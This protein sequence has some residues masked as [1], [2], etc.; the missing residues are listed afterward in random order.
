VSSGDTVG[1][2]Q[3]VALAHSEPPQKNTALKNSSLGVADAI[4]G[5][6]GAAFA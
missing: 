1:C 2:I 4:G 5:L 6:I 3:F